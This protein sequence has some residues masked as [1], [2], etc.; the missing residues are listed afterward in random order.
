VEV[1]A[2]AF[3]DKGEFPEWSAYNRDDVVKLFSTHLITIKL[4]HHKE[5]RVQGDPI[6]EE[7][8]AI[9]HSDKLKEGAHDQR[10]RNVCL[11]ISLVFNLALRYIH[12][13]SYPSDI[14]QVAITTQSLTL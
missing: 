7:R 9:E 5:T 4:H 1:F 12:L 2:D 14:M 8:V 3:L 11:L 10:R 6:V 13:S